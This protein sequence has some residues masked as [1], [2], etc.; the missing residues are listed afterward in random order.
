MGPMRPK[1][2]WRS[3]VVMVGDKLRT[4]RD[5]PGLCFREDFRWEEVWLV[6]LVGWWLWE[7]EVGQWGG[8]RSFPPLRGYPPLVEVGP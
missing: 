8:M 5:I 1:A 4:R 2:V 6:G 3:E 7:D